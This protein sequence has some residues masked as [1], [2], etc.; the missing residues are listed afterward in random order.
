VS[1][2]EQQI[3]SLLDNGVNKLHLRLSEV[4]IPQC[5][6]GYQISVNLCTCNV[7]TV[8]LTLLCIRPIMP[9]IKCICYADAWF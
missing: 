5:V 8:L 4:M 2:L 9:H 7:S 3:G 1:E 6:I